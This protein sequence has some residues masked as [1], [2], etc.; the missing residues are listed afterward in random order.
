MKSRNDGL[1]VGEL[2]M[3]VAALIIVCLA[4]TTFTKKD[5]SMN[6]FD[7]EKTSKIKLKINHFSNKD[8]RSIA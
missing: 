5:S 3:T 1:T 4:W 6:K 7:E 2:T 8:R